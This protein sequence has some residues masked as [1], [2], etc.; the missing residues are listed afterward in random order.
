MKGLR[1]IYALFQTELL[2]IEPLLTAGAGNDGVEVDG[3]DLDR[4]GAT[5]LAGEVRLS[6][7]GNSAAV[8]IAYSTVLGSDKTLT[9]AVQLQ[10]G[11]DGTNW[12]DFGDALSDV[13]TD[14]TTGATYTG[15]MKFRFLNFHLA[16]RFVRAQITATLS[17]ANTDTVIYSAVLVVGN[18]QEL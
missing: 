12:T 2:H 10:D 18:L 11:P 15:T 3:I 17:A 8:V 4:F 7:R 13:I 9:I 16:D 1:D 6:D 5:P 14:P